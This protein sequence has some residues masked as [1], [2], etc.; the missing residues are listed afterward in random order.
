MAAALRIVELK[1][2][3]LEAAAEARERGSG[4]SVLNSLGPNPPLNLVEVET[5]GLIPRKHFQG[6]SL[7]SWTSSIQF[8]L[9]LEA[10]E[11]FIS[12]FLSLSFHILFLNLLGN[13]ELF[14]QVF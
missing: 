3:L 13:Q 1:L 9:L 7:S 5:R 4:R 10:D 6:L 14:F 8:S 12:C 2:Q 11:E